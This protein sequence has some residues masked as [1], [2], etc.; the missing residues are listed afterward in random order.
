MR[1]TWLAVTAVLTLAL[2]SLADRP[3]P[4]PS[5]PNE[6]TAKAVSLEKAGHFLD[7]VAADW[8][9]DRKCGTCHTN[10]PYLIARPAL[11]AK[12][13]AG[14]DEK[15]VRKFFEDRAA[16]WDRGQKGDK[17]RWDTEVVVTGV[18]LAL[19]DAATTGQ[20]H[21]ATRTALDRMWAVQKKTGEWN[22][23]KCNWPP[24]EHDDYYGAVFAAVGVGHAPGGYAKTEKARAG[25]EKL[26]AY[27]KKT[28]PP[29]LHHRAWLL[30]A[31]MKL[32]GLMT[33]EEREK[34]VKDLLA[35]QKAD[36]SWSLPSLGDWQGYDKRPNDLKAPG[37]GYGTGLVVYVLRQAG[38]P[39]NDPAVKKGVDWLKANQ[40]A[41]GRWF[42]QSLNTDRYHYI[43]N[44]GT[45]FAVMAIKACE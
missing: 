31:S 33:K 15:L 35:L 2:T 41:S 45:A 11:R 18:T 34:T 39:A 44:A 1:S 22:W 4:G 12:G 26:R 32:D 43:T 6:A 23:L 5:K 19:H 37:D 28:A 29:S 13:P 27:F 9:R 10:V 40:R 30:W 20:L 24:L 21:A 25:L 38:T 36:G 14:D 3:R 7:A 16:N 8:T 17:P 42:T